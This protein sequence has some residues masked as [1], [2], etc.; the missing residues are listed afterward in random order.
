[1]WIFPLQ[2]QSTNGFA[3]IA[4]KPGSEPTRQQSCPTRGAMFY[5]QSSNSS[6]SPPASP[7]PLT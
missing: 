2:L 1:M 6:C 5:L 7:R 4:G 3:P